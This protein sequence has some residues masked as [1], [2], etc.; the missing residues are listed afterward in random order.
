M[1]PL[2][3]VSVSVSEL[4]SNEAKGEDCDAEE[5]TRV[6]YCESFVNR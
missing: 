4:L 2:L 6:W 1:S 5:A 3:S